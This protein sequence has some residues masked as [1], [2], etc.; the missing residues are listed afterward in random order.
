[1]NAAEL[2]TNSDGCAGFALCWKVPSFV[3]RF[4]G[5]RRAV[6]RGRRCCWLVKQ[7]LF[8]VVQG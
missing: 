7:L 6:R 3:F 8:E 1:M 4:D 2:G 5:C